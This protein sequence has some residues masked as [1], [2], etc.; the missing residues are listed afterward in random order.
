MPADALATAAQ[1][2]CW[3]GKVD[4]QPIAGGI[5]NSNFLICDRGEKFFVRIG[6]DIPMHGVWRWNEL[7]AS[8]AAHAVG[9]SPEVV[10][11]SPGAIVFRFIEGR[12]LAAEDLRDPRM[13]ARAL[14]LVQRCHREIPKQH[15]GPTL[16]FWV[17]QVARAYARVLRDADSVHAEAL[18]RL[19]SIAAE[20]EAAV[21]GV[22]LVFGHNDLLAANFIDEGKRLWLIDWDYAGFNSPLFDLGGL[23]SNSGLS[24]DNERWILKEYFGVA[25]TPALWRRFAAMK[26]AS[27]LR[28]TMWSM[29]SEAYSI[30]D[31]DFGAYTA[32][33]LNRFESAYAA[34]QAL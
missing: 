27:L 34:Y 15:I 13:L 10:Y 3:S 2:S 1:L 9:I 20:L 31:F 16:L 17:F 32:E 33:N 28:E 26:C 24:K 25:P 7:A 6:E 30:V 18:P 11:A 5:T 23:A 8:C 19:E 29:V 14:A 4:P 21:G 12:T 22:E